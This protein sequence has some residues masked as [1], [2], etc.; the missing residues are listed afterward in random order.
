M[1]EF[2]TCVVFH[3]IY[4]IELFYKSLICMDVKYLCQNKYLLIQFSRNFLR[5]LILC[6]VPALHGR[7]WTSRANQS[8]AISTGN[9]SF[10]LLQLSS[11]KMREDGMHLFCMNSLQQSSLYPPSNNLFDVKTKRKG[12]RRSREVKKR[13]K[14]KWDPWALSWEHTHP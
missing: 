12:R 13:R 3:N 4:F 11:A 9:T 14:E 10:S 8:I 2:G 6:T 1:Q 7:I 5:S